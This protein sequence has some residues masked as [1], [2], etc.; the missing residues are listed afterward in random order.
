MTRHLWGRREIENYLCQPGTLLAYAEHLAKSQSAGPLFE[1]G[2][3]EP[4]RAAMQEALAD[5]IGKGPMNDPDDPF[6]KDNKVS[7]ELMPYIL[8]D[9]ATRLGIYNAL[10]KGDFHVLVSH[11]PDQLI[12]EEITQVLDLIHQ[13][14]LNELPF[15]GPSQGKPGS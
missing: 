6:W 4:Y 8:S 5:R 13:T 7:E 15:S 12:A 10:S 2:T 1:A 14:A 3:I 9:F 11:I